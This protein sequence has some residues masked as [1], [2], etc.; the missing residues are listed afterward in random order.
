MALK[1]QFIDDSTGTTVEYWR[2]S[3]FSSYYNWELTEENIKSVTIV[4]D[5]FY[6]ESTRT[7]NKRK[8]MSKSVTLT[9]YPDY[10]SEDVR[11]A[12]YQL[13][14]ETEEWQDAIDC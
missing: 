14:K 4:L 11:E 13:I 3:L 1:K 6:N 9:D 10:N 12:L 7:Q 2:I 5:G 8:I